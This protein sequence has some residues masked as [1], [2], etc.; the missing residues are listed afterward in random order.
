[1]PEGGS[2]D[3]RESQ[4]QRS[5]P[6]AARAEAVH[7]ADA[8]GSPAGGGNGAGSDGGAVSPAPPDAS[9]PSDSSGV[10]KREGAELE[11]P[12]SK[13]PSPP[14]KGR[15]QR[16]Y[17]RESIV[18][19]FKTHLSGD[20]LE[21]K[22]E[23]L[24]AT[25]KGMSG[26]PEQGTGAYTIHQLWLIAAQAEAADRDA[27]LQIDD[28]SSPAPATLDAAPP[29][30]SPQPA[31][32]PQ[33]VEGGAGAEPARAPGGGGGMAA[34]LAAL[35]ARLE[36][37][38]DGSEEASEMSPELEQAL[39][40]YT[41]FLAYADPMQA[42]LDASPELKARLT[43]A[44]TAA[45]KVR[46]RS[47]WVVSEREGRALLVWLRAC[48]SL[49]SAYSLDEVKGAFAAAER[50]RVEHEASW[51]STQ[52]ASLTVLAAAITAAELKA[53]EKMIEL[54]ILR[55][56]AD[57]TSY[58][59]EHIAKFRELHTSVHRLE[60]AN[61][62]LQ[63][64]ASAAEQRAGRVEAELARAH[65]QLATAGRYHGS[66][67]GARRS[68]ARFLV[69][70]ADRHLPAPRSPRLPAAHARSA[71][72]AGAR[73]AHAA[74]HGGGYH[75]GAHENK[76]ARNL[77]ADSNA[78][79]TAIRQTI[80]K[81]LVVS[82]SSMPDPMVVPHHVSCRITGVSP[83]AFALSFPSAQAGK[84]ELCVSGAKVF[85]PATAN[86]SALVVHLDGMVT[87]EHDMGS[88]V[89]SGVVNLLNGRPERVETAD[90]PAG[91]SFAAHGV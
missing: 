75:P 80:E 53:E 91:L 55:S 83:E 61:A 25:A 14:A 39:A 84:V 20:D 86:S 77:R 47:D 28:E 44:V 46:V 87:V 48:V 5:E 81:Q 76:G 56:A 23:E 7:G 65:E 15:S 12:R 3:G 9:C 24:T 35:T 69:Q 58:V 85:M 42:V 73:H 26:V 34:E 4:A 68:R 30:R 8:A 71:T 60:K 67:C 50:W 21:C 64:R 52:P 40:E 1:M 2:S 88:V 41:G 22:V 78:L 59:R 6:H 17:F 19:R 70:R 33:P 90:S 18:A 49:D 82:M 31:A 13:A 66:W 10:R 72:A 43:V 36:A 16:A 74:A 54:E 37:A 11:L 62:E 32:S 29:P 57:G 27:G 51:K 63:A 38:V 89:M 45:A 79:V